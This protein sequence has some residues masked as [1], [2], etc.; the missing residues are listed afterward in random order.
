VANPQGMMTMGIRGFMLLICFIFLPHRSTFGNSYVWTPL[1]ELPGPEDIIAFTNRPASERSQQVSSSQIREILK[2]G[3]LHSEFPKL[4]EP[5]ARDERIHATGVF[6]SRKGLAYFW[7][8]WDTRHLHV[9]NSEGRQC[10]IEMPGNGI[11]PKADTKFASQDIYRKLASVSAEEVIGFFND[12]SPPT[13]STLLLPQEDIMRF[14]R[15]GKAVPCTSMLDEEELRKNAWL[16]LPKERAKLA[17]E[18]GLG[19]AMMGD[20]V[21]R[22]LFKG[23]ELQVRGI[24]VTKEGRI[25]FWD[26]W[27][28]HLLAL[29]DESGGLCV[30]KI[31]E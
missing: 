20:A 5:P 4:D 12:R 11:T 1:K 26:R 15:T 18:G 24:L 14:L 29:R 2:K 17:R 9:A 25:L 6:V 7:T 30:L 31:P 16:T 22:G 21:P 8:M 13:G 19:A 27:S 3:T 23:P 10:I 28:D